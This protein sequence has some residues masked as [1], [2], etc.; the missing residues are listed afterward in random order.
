MSRWI[1]LLLSAAA[2]AV[3]VCQRLVWG[4]PKTSPTQPLNLKN[5]SANALQKLLITQCSKFALWSLGIIQIWFITYLELIFALQNYYKLFNLT[6]ILFTGRGSV[7][8][9]LCFFNAAS[10]WSKSSS[11]DPQLCLRISPKRMKNKTH[12][13]LLPHMGLGIR[14]W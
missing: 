8:L 3:P 11:P 7:S 10:P 4:R 9:K 5:V 6:N 14:H 2:A 13:F 12:F 1:P